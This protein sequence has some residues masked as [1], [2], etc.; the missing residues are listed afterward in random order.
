MQPSRGSLEEVQQLASGLTSQHCSCLVIAQPRNPVCGLPPDAACRKSDRCQCT[1]VQHKENQKVEAASL[2]PS[3]LCNTSPVQTA[4]CKQPHLALCLQA[5]ERHPT[6]DGNGCVNLVCRQRRQRMSAVPISLRVSCCPEVPAS[7]AAASG[8]STSYTCKSTSADPVTSLFWLGSRARAQT[9]PRYPTKVWEQCCVSR[10]HTLTWE[11]LLQL[12]SLLP[13]CRKACKSGN[14]LGT[15]PA[16][17]EPPSN[18]VPPYSKARTCSGCRDSL[19]LEG[20]H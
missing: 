9:S 2:G 14:N 11:S 12:I 8:L 1:L 13:C 18:L 16:V 10:S 4:L 19:R 5:H 17:S 3:A 6:G 7:A 15:S 20:H